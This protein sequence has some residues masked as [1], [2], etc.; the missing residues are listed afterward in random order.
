MTVEDAVREHEQHVAASLDK[1]GFK[2][3]LVVNF[4]GKKKPPLL[5]QLGVWLVNRMGGNISIKYHIENGT[6]NSKKYR[7]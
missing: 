1:Y 7:Q 4:P 5:G 3:L 6:I 2:M